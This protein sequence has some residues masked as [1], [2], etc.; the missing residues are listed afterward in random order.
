MEIVDIRGGRRKSLM[1]QMLRVKMASDGSVWDVPVEFIALNRAQT[2]AR[3]NEGSVYIPERNLQKDTLLLFK[4]DPAEI[5]DWAV[6]N[7]DWE[8][9][10]E[11]AR[12][13]EPPTQDKGYEVDWVRGDHE[14]LEVPAS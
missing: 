2:L 9:V 11:V 8:D 5:E 4:K 10:A 1:P 3:I 14:V 6:N 13:V 7:M 12:M